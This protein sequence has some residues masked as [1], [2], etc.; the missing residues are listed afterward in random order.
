MRSCFEKI[1]GLVTAANFQE[2]MEED[3]SRPLYIPD[4]PLNP[5][6]SFPKLDYERTLPNSALK[7]GFIQLGI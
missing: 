7:N 2:I 1:S 5:E 6:S 4:A 3:R